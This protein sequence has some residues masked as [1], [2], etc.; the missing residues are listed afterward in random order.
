MLF[1]KANQLLKKVSNGIC[2]TIPLDISKI[3]PK[4]HTAACV[5]DGEQ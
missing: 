1:L 5:P 4:A 3:S 2:P